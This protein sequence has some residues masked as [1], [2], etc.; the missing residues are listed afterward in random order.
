LDACTATEEKLIGCFT[1]RPGSDIDSTD[2]SELFVIGTLAVVKRALRTGDVV[3]TI[4]QAT[5]RIVVLQWSARDPYLRAVVRIFPE[6]PTIDVDKVEAS[7]RNLQS[8]IQSTRELLPAISP[9]V[10][11]TLM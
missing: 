11:T 8:M 5:K 2:P 3:Q 6:L 1:R 7:K 9:E 10:Q 4:V